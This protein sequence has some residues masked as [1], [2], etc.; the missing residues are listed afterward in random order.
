MFRFSTEDEDDG[1]V[2]RS[3]AKR[4]RKKRSS[5]ASSKRR[6]GSG[7][8]GGS[9]A[10]AGADAGAGGDGDGDDGNDDGNEAR[11]RLFVANPAGADEYSGEGPRP[12]RSKW[13]ED[14][15]RLFEEGIRIYGERSPKRISE[16]M[17]GSRTNEQVRE[18]IKSFKR[19]S[20]EHVKYVPPPKPAK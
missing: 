15:Q 20:G 8:G 1:F 10:D 12:S 5:S 13:T 4:T 14:E 3:A 2:S 18:R 11:A 16:Y 6:G 19:K 9:G 7:G 17:R